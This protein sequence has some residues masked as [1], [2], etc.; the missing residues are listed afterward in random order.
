MTM[1]ASPQL[2][3][4]HGELKFSADGLFSCRGPVAELLRALDSHFC[5]AAVHRDAE[6]YVSPALISEKTLERSGYLV[7]FPG[8]ASRIEA[9]S[10]SGKYFL[11]PAV[12]YH[13]YE[14]LAGSQLDSSAVMTCA[15]RCF[16]DDPADGRHLWE[17]TMREVVFLGSSEFV[18][19]QR[20]EWLELATRWARALGLDA[21][22]GL[23]SDPF[24]VGGENRGKKILQRVKELKYEL[25]APDLAGRPMAIASFN[26]HEQFFGKRFG[27]TLGNGAPAFSACAGFGLERW[28]LA[29][30][31]RLPANE[32]L[33]QMELLP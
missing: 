20:Q 3:P 33:R 11:S 30:L 27:I 9:S 15:G 23:A 21:S 25:C 14:L 19:A 7:S 31:A 10:R 4:L 1:A 13:A 32:A 18:S 26:L 5:V 6:Q 8:R 2:E 12:C 22:S 28:A 17:F 29:L 24:F 16:R